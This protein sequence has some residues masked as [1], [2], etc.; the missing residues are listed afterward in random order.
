MS[1]ARRVL[2]RGGAW[3]GRAVR[4]S[5]GAGL[6]VFCFGLILAKVSYARATDAALD[7]GD[8]I[9]E[10]G[11]ARVSGALPGDVYQVALNGQP[12]DSSNVSTSRP[13]HEVLDYFQERCTTNGDG[14]GGEL[15]RLAKT[16]RELP[17][18]TGHAGF[19]VV[20]KE[21]EGRG[22]VF[23]MGA[24]HDLSTKDKAGRLRAV[25][26][27]GDFGRLG[28]MRYVSVR[29]DAAGSS[30]AA[31]WTHGTFNVNAMFPTVGDSP[32]EDIGR[33]PR[34]DGTRRLLTATIVGAPFGLNAYEFRGSSTEGLAATDAKLIGAGWKRAAVPE[35]VHSP[36]RF[37]SLGNALD[38]SVTVREARAGK[39]D[40]AYAV[41]RGLGVVAR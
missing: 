7:L 25:A 32:G 16:V 24:D 41:S 29:S 14:L 19:V 30:I 40:I 10:L 17:R 11:D 21:S 35:A 31:L 4:L 6:V 23:C 37:Y 34:A 27:S 9:R 33:V 1:I 22:F 20:R 18:T 28:D 13:L 5:L 8:E 26:E 12:F 38:V 3:I 39:S 2:W 36:S 15:A